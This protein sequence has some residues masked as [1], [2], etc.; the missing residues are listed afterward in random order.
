MITAD[1]R[2]EHGQSAPVGRLARALSVVGKAGIGTPDLAALVRSESV[3]NGYSPIE[4]PIAIED[5]D[6]VDW[7][8]ASCHIQKSGKG[9]SVR[10]RPWL[11]VWGGGLF[12]PDVAAASLVRR[13]GPTNV[14][15]DPFLFDATG[16]QFSDYRTPGQRAAVRTVLGAKPGSSILA[17]LPTGSGKTAAISVPA[18]LAKPNLTV[19]IVPTI[20]LATDLERRLSH[21]YDIN[22]HVA[23][24]GGLSDQ[25]RLLF[26]SRINDGTQWLVIT[27]PES[28]CGSLEQ[29][30]A[31]AARAGRL[32]YLM[33]DEAHI[34]ASWGGSFRPEFQALAGLRRHLQAEASV[35]QSPF[36]TVLLTGTLDDFGL[37]ILRTM[38]SDSELTTV[39]AQ[40]TRPEPSY[41]A[42]EAKDDEGKRLALIDAVRHLPRPLLIYVSLVQGTEKVTASVVAEWL[43]DAG[44]HRVRTVTGATKAVQRQVAVDTM[45]CSKT[46]DEDCDIVVA[47]SAFG[48][49]ID[50][51]DVRSVVHATVP[52]SLDRFYQEVG[53]G[54]R[55]GK[56]SVS[57]VI[58]TPHDRTIAKRL[59]SPKE[60]GPDK[61]WLHWDAMRSS[62]ESLINGN[63]EVSLA[64]AHST[65][66]NPAGELNRGWN[67]HTLA[68][69]ERAG[70]IRLRW[71]GN[72]VIPDDPSEDDVRTAFQSRKMQ[73]EVVFGDLAN[74]QVFRNRWEKYRTTGIERSARSLST[75]ID[76]L[77]SRPSGLHGE[78]NASC[79]NQVFANHFRL[80]LRHGNIALCEV[81]C[82]GCPYCRSL[83][84]HIDVITPIDP[85][86]VQGVHPRMLNAGLASIFRN[87]RIVSVTY[88]SPTKT[89]WDE[90]AELFQNLRRQ[91]IAHFVIPE[92]VLGT[93]KLGI[94]RWSQWAAIDSSSDWL[95][96]DVVLGLP[97]V[98]LLAHD[99]DAL[100]VKRV[101]HRCQHPGLSLL[102]HTLNAPGP[103]YA[104]SPLRGEVDLSIPADEL[105]GSI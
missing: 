49:G 16:G 63:L 10:A 36:T 19:V 73:I 15:G 3:R 76:S 53:R 70:M 85:P 9:I 102:V 79:L 47:S 14:P 93:E 17:V 65:I 7:G 48:L 83:G 42:C 71:L 34:V 12:T 23:Y 24:H 38:F 84:R 88:K 67:L 5:T 27:S 56:A 77:E 44:F 90:L 99:A 57:L 105:L 35:A 59:A 4:L 22:H 32:R 39:C 64:A 43:S 97:Q 91:G 69:M 21:E 1:S 6:L 81:T 100:T 31:A 11:P 52:E 28:A 92:R 45:R 94:S 58:H 75:M 95:A 62:S 80:Q 37:Q 54:G 51:D 41:W 104:K 103:P 68:M 13:L 29:A 55:D 33:I 61:A 72:L 78:A 2:V 60:I 101:L 30:L 50:I 20:S 25:D 74:E 46:P 66:N 86:S 96:D 89:P 26:R 98:V 40:S 82:G 8:L 18:F 87:Q